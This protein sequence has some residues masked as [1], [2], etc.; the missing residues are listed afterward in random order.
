M[1]DV[2]QAVVERTLKAYECDLIVERITADFIRL[3]ALDNRRANEVMMAF[4]LTGLVVGFSDA[5]QAKEN[6]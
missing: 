4:G 2:K 6:K 1:D 5:M 3:R